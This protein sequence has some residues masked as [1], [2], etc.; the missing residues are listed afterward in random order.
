MYMARELDAGDVILQKRT[1]IAPDE[2]AQALT[3]RLA[4]L[5]AEALSEAVAALK[6]GTANRIPQDERYQTYAPML[7][8]E[9]SPIDW[10]R[11]AWSIDCQVRGLIPWPCAAAELAGRRVKVFGTAPGGETRQAPG[12]ILAA[13]K[14][15]IEVACGDQKSLLITELQPEGSKRMTAEAYLAGHPIKV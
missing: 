6:A 2:N 13:G 1:P 5:G 7:S 14:S 9:M 3:A 11:S 15:G 8:K 10:S 12:T 4:K